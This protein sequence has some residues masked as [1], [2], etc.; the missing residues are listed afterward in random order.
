[1]GFKTFYEQEI[2]TKRHPTSELTPGN[3]DPMHRGQQGPLDLNNLTQEGGKVFIQR[4]KEKTEDR[5]KQI[6][7]FNLDINT[8]DRFFKD[9]YD[10]R[11]DDF[12]KVRSEH[13]GDN[14]YGHLTII[15]RMGKETKK[16][17]VSDDAKELLP[18]PHQMKFIKQVTH[19][20][21]PSAKIWGATNVDEVYKLGDYNGK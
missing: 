12:E 19:F 14:L 10:P 11:W 20:D 18:E 1:M 17:L 9:P 5:G 13:Q 21:S 7:I 2:L 16:K 4:L 3:K 6:T 15:T 8:F